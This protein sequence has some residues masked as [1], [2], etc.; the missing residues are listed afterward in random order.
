MHESTTPRHPWLILIAGPVL[1]GTNG[2]PQL[3]AANMR[4]LEAMSL[5]IWQRGHIPLVGEWVAGPIITAAGGQTPG[6]EVWQKLQYP[7]AHR[8]LDRC[9]AVL[10]LPGAS[11]GA[12]MDVARARERGIPVYFDINEIPQRAEATTAN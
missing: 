8:L 6:D 3:V 4:T 2:D 11:R 5:P 9:D 12:D 7:V 10:R 1:S